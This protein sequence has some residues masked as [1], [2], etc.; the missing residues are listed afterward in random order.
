LSFCLLP[1]STKYKPPFVHAHTLTHA[2]THQPQQAKPV[3]KEICTIYNA[4][5]NDTLYPYPLEQFQQQPDP[6][7]WLWCLSIVAWSRRGQLELGS[8]CLLPFILVH[9]IVY[10]NTFYDIVV[11]RFYTYIH[12]YSC[13]YRTTC[14][15][16]F[17]TFF[18]LLKALMYCVILLHI[19]FIAI[20]RGKVPRFSRFICVHVVGVRLSHWSCHNDNSRRIIIIINVCDVKYKPYLY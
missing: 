9:M 7:C 12:T 16:L 5:K 3:G 8:H 14:Q 15:S 1:F 2:Q 18:R 6:F 19:S 20:S 10:Y 13:F 17:Y 4:K 11:S